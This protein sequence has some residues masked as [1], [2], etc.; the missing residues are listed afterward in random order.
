[1]ASSGSAPC[2]NSVLSTRWA[3]GAVEGEWSGQDSG[4]VATAATL[5]TL[6]GGPGVR[7]P[8]IQLNAC[9]SCELLTHTTHRALS[10]PTNQQQSKITPH[11]VCV[12]RLVHV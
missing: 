10:K 8:H 12:L 3:C 6:T 1:M 2:C 4:H 11:L 5:E 9:E 7:I